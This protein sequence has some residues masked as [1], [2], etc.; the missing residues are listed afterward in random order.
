VTELERA[1]RRLLRDRMWDRELT[2]A[3]KKKA[4]KG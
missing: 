2:R 1:F 4:G 3:K